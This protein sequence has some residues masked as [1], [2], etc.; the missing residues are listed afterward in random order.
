MHALRNS[1]KGTVVEAD[2]D[3][4]LFAEALTAFDMTNAVAGVNVT[5]PSSTFRFRDV[6]VLTSAALDIVLDEEDDIFMVAEGKLMLEEIPD[7]FELDV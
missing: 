1:T 2:I 6:S 3:V 5:E 4:M 7:E